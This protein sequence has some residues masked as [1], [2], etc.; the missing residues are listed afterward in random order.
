M[1]HKM[2]ISNSPCKW[3]DMTWHQSFHEVEHS[4]LIDCFKKHCDKWGFQL[5]ICP[6]TGNLH[7][8]CRISM[9]VKI[10]HKQLVSMEDF[11]GFHIRPTV[12]ENIGNLNYVTKDASRME[13]PWVW[14]KMPA[15]VPRQYRETIECKPHPWQSEFLNY[16]EEWD[17]KHINILIES[18]GVVGKSTLINYCDIKGYGCIIPVMKEY[19]DLMRAV[20]SQPE[21]KLYLIDIPRALDHG[22]MADL[23][24]AIETIKGGY[25]WDDRYKFVKRHFDCPNVWVFT[26][27]LPN[28]ECL[29]NGRWRFWKLI[30]NHL[31]EV[32]VKSFEE[33]QISRKFIQDK[34]S[35][36][37]ETKSSGVLPMRYDFA[38]AEHSIV[39]CRTCYIG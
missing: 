11:N 17:T 16:S 6:E 38:C 33:P 13:G 18:K 2:N 39:G 32:D 15:Y 24:A 3:F 26:N 34:S 7:Y 20:C 10:R 5:E 28:L 31:R 1:E 25:A 29:S 8:Q 27:H 4:V 9:K 19:K 21:S 22:K 37:S 23:F 30:N 12:K 35:K 36:N 14:D